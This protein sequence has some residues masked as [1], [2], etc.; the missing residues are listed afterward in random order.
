MA[1]RYVVQ[2]ASTG[3]TM[4]NG[5]DFV[6]RDTETDGEIAAAVKGDQSRADSMAGL[7]NFQ[8]GLDKLA[9]SLDSFRQQ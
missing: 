2:P 6:V 7:L 1:Q 4:A 9:Q 3:G 8:D 5:Y